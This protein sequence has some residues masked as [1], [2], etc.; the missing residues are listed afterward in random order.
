MLNYPFTTFSLNNAPV[1][2]HSTAVVVVVP[3]RLY[4]R[5]CEPDEPRAPPELWKLTSVPARQR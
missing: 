5:R 2:I 4:R 1:H 3:F